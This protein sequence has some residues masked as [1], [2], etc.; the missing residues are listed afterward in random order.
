[1]RRILVT[2]AGGFLGSHLTDAL[3]ACGWDV[4][5]LDDWS[6]GQEANLPSGLRAGQFTSVTADVC[7]SGAIARAAEGV[8][9]IAHL[10][11]FKIPRYGGRLKT[12]NVNDFGVRSILEAARTNRAHVLFT[13]TSDCYGKNPAVPFSEQHDSVLGPANIAR[14]AYAASKIF[15]EH[16]CYAYREEYGV[17]VSIARIF[18][19]Y[20]PRHHLSWWGGPQSVFLTR[21]L[22]GEPLV[23]HGDG[24]QTRSFTYVADTIAGLVTILEA[25]RSAVDGELLNVGSDA[26]ITIADL[27]RLIWQLVRPE[28]PPR[29][30]FISYQ[31]IADRPYEDV[32]RRVPDTS[33]LKALGW[34]PIWTLEEGLRETLLWH[35]AAIRE[36][37]E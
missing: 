29:C 22:S 5:G 24:R 1:M 9:A 16:L 26:E 36:T 17:S 32:R 12:L 6:H 25:D 19:S 20:G 3:L 34:R 4:V 10:A 2:G 15:G 18:G 8:Q 13:S 31:A 33:K 35:R 11:A 23:I 21:A 28:E 30:E 27:A 14:W 7:D 37:K